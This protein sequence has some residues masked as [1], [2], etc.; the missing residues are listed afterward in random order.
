[1][2]IDEIIKEQMNNAVDTDALNRLSDSCNVQ[3]ILEK[4]INGESIF[5]PDTII[6]SLKELF[7]LEI[8][9]AIFCGIEILSVCVIM[10]LLQNME[11]SFGKKNTA[12]LSKLV[13]VIAVIGV[14]ITNYTQSYNLVIDT[15]GRMTDTMEILV[16]VLIGLLL[17]MG[18]LTSGS[19]LS[20]LILTCITIF[21]IIIKKFIL[22]ALYI[23]T[24]ITLIN[25]LTE[26]DYVNQLASFINKAA[27]F[28]MGVILTLMSGIITIQGMITN[29][30]DSLILGTAKYSLSTFI[31]I[32]GGFTSDTIE[33]FLKCM[34]T[35]KG[36][37][38]VFG[39][40]VIVTIMVTPLVKI[41][42]I[43][44]IYKITAI[45][46]EPIAS[47]KITKGISN[48]GSTLISM[49]AVIFFS[50]L[51]FIIFI[52]AIIIGLK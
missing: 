24:S 9:S 8:K 11:V 47:P 19:I 28:L 6:E 27:L 21:Q 7:F 1:M 36:V 52:T 44:V 29:A 30:S 34:S 42:T 5:Q 25:C 43:S 45:I 2:D 37:V 22:P 48:V 49:A 15:I 41:L 32:V 12:Q 51:L 18:K 50:S 33:V 46:S 14:I 31:P 40:I 20:P 13:C 4:T 39:I 26:K 17:A 10:G 23:S 16:P 3:D 35:I 38:G